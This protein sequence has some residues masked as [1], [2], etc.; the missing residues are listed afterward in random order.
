[1]DIF[2]LPLNTTHLRHY[3]KFIA[4]IKGVSFTKYRREVE[5][6]LSGFLGNVWRRRRII[7]RLLQKYGIN[8]QRSAQWHSKRS[9]MITASEV[10]KA[11]KDAT[12][13][14]RRELILK[15]IEGAKESDGSA[16]NTACAWGTQFE[17][18]AKMI[19]C[20]LNGGGEVVDTSC[21]VHP[22]HSFLGASP[23]GIYFPESKSD[24]RWG[25]LIEFKCPISR[26]FDETTP[27][28]DAYYHQMQ[29]Q[30]EC[31]NLDECD[32]VE[33]KFMTMTQTE[34][35]ASTSP[36]KGRFAIFDSGAISYDYELDPTWR[37]NLSKI[38]EDFRVIHWVLAN[39][40]L[41]TVKRD[42]TWLQTHIDELKS[43]WEEI[44][45]HRSNGTVPEKNEKVIEVVQCEP[46]TAQPDVRSEP[47]EPESS[48][49]EPSYCSSSVHK[50]NAKT[51]QFDLG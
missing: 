32:Y 22:E 31:T 39:W 20:K 18:I 30:M 25:K 10:T 5:H 14:A 41:E 47:L 28:P 50:K 44:L 16:M 26:K 24:V 48:G 1:M 27:I 35:N 37:S 11:F 40:R 42:Y 29:M 13:S 49:Q 33:M 43:T 21:V 19:Y 3:M 12:P 23:D 46:Q 4:M 34:W 36:Y 7:Y 8:D 38:E 51:L 6:I 17:P 15:K 9:E 45:N 2:D